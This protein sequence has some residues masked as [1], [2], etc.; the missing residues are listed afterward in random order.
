MSL[1]VTIDTNPDFAPKNALLAPE[2]LISGNPSFKTWAQDA[3]KGE[4]VLTGVWKQRR[5]RPIPSRAPPSSS[6]TFSRVLS[7]LRKRVVRR[8]LIAPA[9]AS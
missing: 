1:L 5:A 6:A 7:K 9:T 4:K 8:R 3:S 2:R